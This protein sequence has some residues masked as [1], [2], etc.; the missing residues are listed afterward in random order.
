MFSSF[1]VC[2]SSNSEDAI[3]LIFSWKQDRWNRTPHDVANTS[4]SD[5]EVIVR[6]LP[7]DPE[8]FEHLFNPGK[9]KADNVV[10]KILAKARELGISWKV[11]EDEWQKATE[12]FL[13]GKRGVQ[14]FSECLKIDCVREHI[15]GKQV[16]KLYDPEREWDTLAH[17]LADLGRDRL[18]DTLLGIFPDFGCSKV[19]LL[20]GNCRW[21]KYFRLS[22]CWL[23][24]ALSPNFIRFGIFGDKLRTSRI[25]SCTS[26]VKWKWCLVVK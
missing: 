25:L 18:L 22:C 24:W 16:V 20:E 8:L 12:M 1:Y 11:N 7:R 4:Y 19:R 6:R 26:F 23:W 13:L 14:V 2:S 10:N 21:W 3:F 17:A 9:K 15:R 5:E